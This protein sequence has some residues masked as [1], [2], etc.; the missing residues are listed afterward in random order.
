MLVD[1][2]SVR[3]A[4]KT[5][6]PLLAAVWLAGCSGDSRPA[7]PARTAAAP[8]PVKILQFYVSPAVATAGEKVSLC[9]GVENATAVALS[10]AVE[11][12]DPSPNRCIQFAARRS[13][14]YVLTA[15]GASGG[16][17]TQSLTLRVTGKAAGA[18]AP[19][20][21]SRMIETF[22]ASASRVAAGQPVTV[23]YVVR[24]ASSVRIDPPVGDIPPGGRGCVVVRPSRTTTYTLRVAGTGREDK[25]RLTVRVTGS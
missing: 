3:Q 20:P 14:T 25:E 18:P 24:G 19:E 2:G 9:Y 15:T 11:A 4:L 16:P 17:V 13:G 1:N 22:S 8:A 6:V 23:C 21:G 10:P 7:A 12:I 5:V